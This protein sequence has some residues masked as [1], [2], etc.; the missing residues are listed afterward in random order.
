MR[1][2]PY[3]IVHPSSILTYCTIKYILRISQV[4][5]TGHEVC[6]QSEILKSRLTN[7]VCANLRGP[8]TIMNYVIER[9]YVY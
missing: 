2:L 7:Y 9:D 4:V 3:F 6:K 5:N 8:Y 1:Y